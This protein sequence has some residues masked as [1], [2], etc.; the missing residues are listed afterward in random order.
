MTQADLA[1]AVGLTQH[2]LSTIERFHG[3]SK[4]ETIGAL[5]K[6]LDQPPEIF[7]TPLP[8]GSSLLPRIRSSPLKA[9]GHVGRRRTT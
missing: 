8:L 1:H 9:R 4:L 7:L 3:N 2:H 5:A 6:A